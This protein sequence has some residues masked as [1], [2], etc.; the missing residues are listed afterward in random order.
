MIY[1]FFVCSV[2]SRWVNSVI[3]SPIAYKTTEKHIFIY[4][5]K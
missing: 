2:S 1:F 5:P 4:A 3:R